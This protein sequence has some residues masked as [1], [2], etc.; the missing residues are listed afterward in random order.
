MKL[1]NSFPV[2]SPDESESD[3]SNASFN[4]IVASSFK[5]KPIVSVTKDS[6]SSQLS[7]PFSS[8]SPII[9]N[10]SGVGGSSSDS[11]SVPSLSD[12]SEPSSQSS[13]PSLT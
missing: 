6:A 8:A 7:A 11:P 5:E 2:K 3:S 4:C 1:S 10:S 13:S 9:S 12:S